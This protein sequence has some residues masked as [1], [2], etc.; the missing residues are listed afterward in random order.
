MKKKVRRDANNVVCLTLGSN[1]P[2]TEGG[3]SLI[4]FFISDM[5]DFSDLHDN[6]KRNDIR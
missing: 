5:I 6:N 2:S 3:I 1:F 4:F